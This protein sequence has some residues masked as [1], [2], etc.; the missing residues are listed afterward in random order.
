MFLF[1]MFLIAFVVGAIMAIQKDI[2]WQGV[3]VIGI[4]IVMLLCSVIAIVPSGHVGV[5]TVFG[6]VQDNILHE[7]LNAIAPW[8][9][10]HMMSIRQQTATKAMNASSSSGVTVDLSVTVVYRLDPSHAAYIYRNVGEDYFDILVSPFINNTF[11]N[12]LVQYDAEALYTDMR[13]PVNLEI[14]KLL[15]E[16][17]APQGI[18]VLRTPIENMDLP[19]SLRNKIVEREEAEQ[20]MLKMEYKLQQEVLEAER[21]AIEAGGVAEYQRIVN[22]TITTEFLQWK[23]LQVM[24]SLAGSPNTTFVLAIGE[25]GMPLILNP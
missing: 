10:A 14:E 6:K 11:K 16:F 2:R 15:T 12:L 5:L 17:L 20:D 3:T 18:I 7:G 21:M 8:A 24:E 19:T 4:S 1:V 23:S 9:D 25:D 13:G 22:S